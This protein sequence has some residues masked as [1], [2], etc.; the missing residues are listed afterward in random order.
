MKIIFSVIIPVFNEERTIERVV[1]SLYQFADKKNI[2]VIII[3]SGSTDKTSAKISKLHKKFTNV[4]IVTQT[5]EQFNHGNTRNLGVRL[6]KGKYILFISGDAIPLNSRMFDYFI[7]DFE[8]DEK[9][10]AVFG[11]QIP[12][13]NTSFIQKIET[14]RDFDI[15]DKYLVNNK[16]IFDIKK[17]FIPFIKENLFLWYF[18]SNV[19]ACYRRS[20]L[21]ET[22]FITTDHGEDIFIGKAILEKGLKKIYDQRIS[23][24]HSHN[25]NYFDY[26]IRDQKEIRIALVGLHLGKKINI[27]HKIMKIFLLKT[28]KLQKVKYFGDLLVLYLIKLIAYTK[29]KI[30]G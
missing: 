3:N 10:V 11:R 19:C 4:C 6:S 29:I 18:I 30:F 23:V 1:S 17:P 13:K 5:K 2:E 22:P 14:T 21:I 25:Y 7:K 15:L 24:R 9:I 26:F 20:F 28:T 12:H 8:N 16:L 27:K